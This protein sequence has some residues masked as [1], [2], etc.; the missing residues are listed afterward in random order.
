MNNLTE[1][2]ELVSIYFHNIFFLGKSILHLYAYISVPTQVGGYL[3][4]C[5]AAFSL[6]FDKPSPNF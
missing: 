4:K 2:V 5:A 1:L 3:A 6:C